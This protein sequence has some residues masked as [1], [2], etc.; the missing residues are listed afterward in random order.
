MTDPRISQASFDLIVS[1]EVVSRA[2]Y[3]KKYKRPEWPK[4]RSGITVA[5]GYDLG[6]AT[7][8][9]IRDDWAHLVPPEMLTAMIR[10]S[11][12]TGTDAEALLPAVRGSI[13]IEWNQAVEV[14]E[15]TD[16]PEWTEKVCKAIPGAADLPPDCLGALVSLAYN[17]GIGCFTLNGDRY[18]EGRAIRAH[19][20]NGE[21][22]KV[23]SEFRSMSRLWPGKDERGLPIRREKEAKLWEVGLLGRASNLPAAQPTTDKPKVKE[24]PPPLAPAPKATEIAKDI[25]VSTAKGSTGTGA[26]GAGAYAA[27]LPE[28]AISIIVLIG[29]LGTL[30]LVVYAVRDRLRP[31]VARGKG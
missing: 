23:P 19:V 27:G 6:Y 31:V 10:C 28:W 9:K 2:V 22:S 7:P 1:C 13:L 21:L 16:I 25:A 17:R 26:G 5:I 29:I 8:R 20:L 4:G 30:A 12:V 24:A 3:E 15:D 14:F 11:G 18:R